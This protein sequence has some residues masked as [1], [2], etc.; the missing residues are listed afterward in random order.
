MPSSCYLITCVPRVDGVSIRH[1]VR[2]GY[3]LES[4]RAAYAYLQEQF[5]D[6]ACQA[7]RSCVEDWAHAVLGDVTISQ[8]VGIKKNLD[9]LRRQ[10]FHKIGKI[11]LV[12]LSKL[13]KISGK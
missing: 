12:R 2:G 10:L 4:Y 1:D 6:I 13:R 8:T 7:L 3:S 11:L 5:L 9:F